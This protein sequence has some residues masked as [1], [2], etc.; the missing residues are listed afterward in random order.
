MY[1]DFRVSKEKDDVVSTFLNFPSILNQNSGSAPIITVEHHS[2]D[3]FRISGSR[4][5]G[6]FMLEKEKPSSG[7]LIKFIEPKG[8]KNGIL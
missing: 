4:T 7:I 3:S 6:Y 1:E 8:R 5:L 2:H